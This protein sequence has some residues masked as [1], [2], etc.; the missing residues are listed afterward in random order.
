MPLTVEKAIGFLKTFPP[1]ATL[2]GYEGEMTGIVIE[3][4]AVPQ[5]WL[6]NK[7]EWG[8]MHNDGRLQDVRPQEGKKT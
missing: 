5:K 1:E 7:R 4:D 8:Y 3:M 6:G 2:R